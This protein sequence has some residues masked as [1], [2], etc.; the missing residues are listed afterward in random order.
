MTT[1]THAAALMAFL[2]RAEALRYTPPGRYDWFYPTRPSK[3]IGPHTVSNGPYR[4]ATW[5]LGIDQ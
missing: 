3:Q 4:R 1:T 5:Q 2:T